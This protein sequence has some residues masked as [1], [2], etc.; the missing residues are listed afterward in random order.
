MKV[1]YVRGKAPV[2]AITSPR[3]PLILA[4]YA[5]HSGTKA[6]NIPQDLTN[7]LVYSLICLAQ[8]RCARVDNQEPGAGSLLKVKSILFPICLK[9]V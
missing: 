3:F 4:N 2:V 8:S 9:D 7:S 6:G 1:G 5:V